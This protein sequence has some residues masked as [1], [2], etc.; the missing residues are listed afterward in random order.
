V[1]DTGGNSIGT[2]DQKKFQKLVSDWG[3]LPPRE[4]QR[5][6]QELTQ[7]M[8]PRHRDAI[9]SYFRALSNPA[10]NRKN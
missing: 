5:A 2:V 4:Q 6:L 10:F 8:L 3:R 9:E 1:G 7:G